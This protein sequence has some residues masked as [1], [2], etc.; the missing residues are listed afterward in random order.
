MAWKGKCAVGERRQMVELVR[1]G[2]EVTEVAAMFGVA[3]KT[4][5]KWLNRSLALGEAGLVD[6]PRAREHVERFDG[7]AV[8]L[9]VAARR[10]HPTWGPRKILDQL[11][12]RHPRLALPAVSTAGELLKRMGLVVARQ[13]RP[14][15]G[16]AAYQV[17]ATRP[18][19]PNDRW[20]TDFKGNFLTLNGSRC[21]PFTLRDA[22]SRKVLDI[23][24]FSGE[25]GVNV[26]SCYERAFREHGLPNEIHSDNGKPFASHGLARLSWVMV[27]LLKLGIRPVFSRPG[28]PQDNGGHERMHRDLKAETAWPPAKTMRGQQK[29]FDTFRRIF[30]E[31]RPHEAL[32]GATPDSHWTPSPRTY[33]SSIGEPEYPAHWE[34]RQ[35]GQHGRIFWRGGKVNVTTALCGE[36]VGLEPLSDGQWR[37]HFASLA[38]GVLDERL[39]PKKVLGLRPNRTEHPSTMETHQ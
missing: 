18:K 27:Y 24:A 2:M 4:A 39:N 23:R 33:P 37:I 11:E 10:A 20:T 35:V 38:I 19:H 36:R 7:P 21:F 16:V 12:A 25:R 9:I 29:R 3:R 15:Q 17:G 32:D 26:R 8:A 1:A 14:P 28:K 13:R 5:H 6:L 30:N 22:V 34:Q 31:E